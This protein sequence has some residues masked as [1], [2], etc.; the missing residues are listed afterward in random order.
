MSGHSKWSTIKRKKEKTDSQRAKIF[1]KLGR[2]IAVAVRHGGSDPET[3]S[4]LKDSIAKARANNMP[5]DNVIRCIKKAEG[6]GNGVNYDEIVYEG[7][8]PKGIAILVEAATDNKNR[9][10]AD[11]RHYFDKF[12]G[13][14][15]QSGSVS[16]LFQK[17]GVIYISVPVGVEEDSVLEAALEAGAEDVEFNEEICRITTAPNDFGKVYEALEKVGYSFEEAEVQY[18]PQTT[19][20]L[21]DEKDIIMMNRLIEMFEENDDVQ[22]FWHN[23]ENDEE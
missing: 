7:Y 22:N 8:G 3:N 16:F 2:E 20:K 23:W 14:L 17:A 18:L 19:V 1:T 4:R 10:A 9:T 21:T 13:S 12:G 11:I 5:S 6:A 15:G